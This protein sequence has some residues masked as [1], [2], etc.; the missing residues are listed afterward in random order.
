MFKKEKI[1]PDPRVGDIRR[2]KKFFWF[3]TWKTLNNHKIFVWLQFALV[4]EEYKT[5]SYYNKYGMS[6]RSY[7]WEITDIFD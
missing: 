6:S 7:Y 4:K 5:E 3:P 1:P 2:R